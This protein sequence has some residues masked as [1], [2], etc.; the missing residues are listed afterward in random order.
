M[1]KSVLYSKH[2]LNRNMTYVIEL[3]IQKINRIHLAK[4]ETN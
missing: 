2:F 1:N 3:L 4:Q